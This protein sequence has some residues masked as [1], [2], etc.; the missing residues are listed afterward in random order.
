[1]VQYQP[2]KTAV[3]LPQVWKVPDKTDKKDITFFM[4]AEECGIDNC[5]CF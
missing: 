1:M 5:S 4:N 3:V 2:N